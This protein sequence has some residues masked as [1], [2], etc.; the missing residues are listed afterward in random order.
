MF[1]RIEL[2]DSDVDLDELLAPKPDEKERY[3]D[4]YLGEADM[5]IIARALRG[6]EPTDDAEAH[7]RRI[8]LQGFVYQLNEYTLEGAGDDV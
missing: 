4:F 2:D 3:H 7:A 5:R 1:E 6:D 8:L